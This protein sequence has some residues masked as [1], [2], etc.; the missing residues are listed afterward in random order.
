M[1]RETEMVTM[2]VEFMDGTTEDVSCSFFGT[3]VDNDQFIIFS[4]AD[5]EEEMVVP[6][7]MFRIEAVKTI[8]LKNRFKVSKDTNKH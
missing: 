8:R 3:S 1:E 6:D 5:M 2:T 4:S 7:V